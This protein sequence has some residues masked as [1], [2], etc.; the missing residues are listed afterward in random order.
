MLNEQ[1]TVVATWGF[2]EVSTVLKGEVGVL[3]QPET[4]H[5]NS[6]SRG[7]SVAKVKYPD[8]QE[9]RNSAWILAKTLISCSSVLKQNAEC[10][11]RFSV[12]SPLSR[13]VLIS[14]QPSRTQVCITLFKTPP[15]HK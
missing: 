14:F 1:A 9:L 4:Q 2:D 10:H 15:H 6:I 7:I 13:L 11:I 3:L 8:Q 12:A 5:T